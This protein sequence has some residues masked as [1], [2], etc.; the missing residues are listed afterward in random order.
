MRL[1]KMSNTNQ[2]YGNAIHTLFSMESVPCCIF[3]L[4]RV[5]NKHSPKP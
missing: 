4:S 2:M 1:V 5:I 3:I